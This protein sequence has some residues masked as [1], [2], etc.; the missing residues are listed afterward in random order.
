[1]LFVLLIACA[2]L[3][4]LLLARF[5]ARQKEFAIRASLGAAKLRIVRQLLAESLILA[6]LGAVFGLLA[7]AWGI[8]LLNQIIPAEIREAILI[9]LDGKVLAFTLMLSLL[10]GLAFG[11]V[12]AWQ[13]ARP[14]LTGSLKEGG[15]GA[16]EG[17]ARH[18]F[19]HGLVVSKISLA[20]VLLIGA[21]L[22]IRSFGRVR[23]I[24]PGIDLENVVTM[25]FALPKYKYADEQQQ[26]NFFE[27]L[28]RQTAALPG[29]KAAS[30]NTTLLGGWQ[31]GYHVQGQPQPLPG[32]GELCDIATISPD[33]FKVMGIQLLR[34]RVFSEADNEH[35]QK[36][37]II[38]EK[39]ARK[40][41]P[42]SDPLGHQ[43]IIGGDTNE[44]FAIVGVVGHVKNYGVDAPSREEVICLSASIRSLQ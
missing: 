44:V 5:A 1:V 41:W 21:C 32:Q 38:D 2:N 11:L 16:G 13:A 29:V 18:R 34:G 22:L 15:P 35:A 3:A 12:P 23:A 8:Q 39:F 7:A 36:V 14:N 25:Y 30:I 6:L 33:H 4:N 24:S 37:V 17:R 42:N 28:L 9:N 10:S 43:M 19:R 31:T 26:R 20:L 27:S 40:Y